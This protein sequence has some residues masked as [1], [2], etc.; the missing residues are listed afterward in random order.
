MAAANFDRKGFQTL[1]STLVPSSFW[2]EVYDLVKK[3]YK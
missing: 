3:Q 2:K 1:Y